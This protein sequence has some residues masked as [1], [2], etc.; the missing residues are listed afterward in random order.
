[1]DGVVMAWK[2]K[3]KWCWIIFTQ[4]GEMGEQ[5]EIS[6]LI[7]AHQKTFSEFNQNG[8]ESLRFFF[9]HSGKVI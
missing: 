2:W 6:Q 5:F 1:M 7:W 9:S 4:L 8:R 3:M